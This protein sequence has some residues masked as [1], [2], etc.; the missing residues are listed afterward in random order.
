MYVI[1]I[2][3]E[4]ASEEIL[5]K[6]EYF[7]QYGDLMKV[8]VNT[9]NVYNAT[10]G[11]ASYSAYFTFSEARESANAILVSS[12]IE[13]FTNKWYSRWINLFCMIGCSEHRLALLNFVSSS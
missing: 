3:P 7:G 13:K 5:K 8:V 4:I 6:T 12:P 11:G 2:A 1:G 9:N 10:K